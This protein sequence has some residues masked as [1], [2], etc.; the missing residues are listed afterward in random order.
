MRLT[1]KT[2][3]GAA[4]TTVVLLAAGGIIAGVVNLSALN[5]NIE[6]IV[7]QD[8]VKVRIANEILSL[9]N[10]NG[11]ANF[12]LTLAS[13]AAD[14]S[15]IE[16]RISDNAKVITAKLE[17][18]EAVVYHPEG[19][20][21]VAAIKEA[22][23]LYVTSFA[24]I[25]ELVNADKKEEAEQAVSSHLVPALGKLMAAVDSFVAFQSDLIE[26]SGR[27]AS[28]AYLTARMVML[29]LLTV[30]TLVAIGVGVW[31]VLSIT[32][33]VSSAL[34][35]AN[36]V[37]EGDLNATASVKSNDE[38]KDLIDALNMMVAKL[39]EVVGEVTI[40]TR[41][42]ASG[43][44]ELSAAAEQLSQ[45]AVE[46]SSSTEE[47]SSSVEQMAANIKQNADNSAQTESIARQAA[48]D[49]RTSGQAVGEAVKAMETIAEKILIVQE[50]ARQTD[51]LA[52]NA[53]VE[54]A[55]AGEHGRGFAVVA[56][57]VR[58]LA[59]RSQAAAQEIAGL[60]GDTVKAAQSAGEMLSKLVPEIQ[61]TSELVAEI[62]AASNEQNAGAS[63]IN[64]AIQQLDKVTQQNTSAAEEMSSTAEELS[65]QAEQ[66][67]SSISYFRLS[68]SEGSEA[69]IAAKHTARA[70]AKN[71]VKNGVAELQA[72]VAAAAPTLGKAKSSVKANGGF[73]FDMSG[74]ADALDA[75]FKR[76][77]IA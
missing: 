10:D 77:G 19:R 49:A 37:A 58:K 5:G 13:S 6:K 15:K 33:A 48:V 56:S 23:A 20:K 70:T 66:L 21:R 16:T 63:Q 54:A 71:S 11:R 43:S 65:T 60:S 34:S 2:K 64:A 53:A 25:K 24:E 68:E 26:E 59:E 57:E 50:I 12:E 52:L 67:Q 75:E 42:V 9:V 40:A 74:S 36:A 72:R 31:I 32:R 73:A 46:Q 76:Q 22:R 17:E 41:N 18:V 3:L 4:F 14:R 45:G 7:Q 30:A 27:E 1:L 8:W 69:K 39:R 55:R 38:I 44:Q 35:L 47:A 29:V 62:S 28:A 51:L 61:K